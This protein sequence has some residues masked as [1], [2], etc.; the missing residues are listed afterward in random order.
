MKFI[1]PSIG[2]YIQNDDIVITSDKKSKVYVNIPELMAKYGGGLF[3]SLKMRGPVI[4]KMVGCIYESYI[5]SSSITKNP[6]TG[7]NKI[8]KKQ[9]FN[10]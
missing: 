4:H 2:K 7:K 9:L 5:S 8:T 3:H 6:K 1:F 10:L